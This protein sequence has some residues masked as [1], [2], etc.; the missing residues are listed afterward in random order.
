VEHQKILWIVSQINGKNN[1][2]FGKLFPT[3]GTT[4]TSLGILSWI[5]N[6]SNK[7]FGKFFPTCGTTKT[8]LDIF[9]RNNSASNKKI[10]KAFYQLVEQQK[11]LWTV[12]F[13]ST[14]E[15]IQNAEDFLTT[16][17]TTKNS[18]DSFSDQRQ[19]QHKI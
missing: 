10:W 5:N 18:L 8:S 12:S 3:C 1:T 13:R 4:K 7:K 11:I 2:K 6:A 15:T 9:S 16:C 17:R 19:K 14:R